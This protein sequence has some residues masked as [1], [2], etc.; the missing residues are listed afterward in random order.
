MMV[1]MSG[2]WMPIVLSAVVVFVASWAIHMFIGWHKGEYPAVPNQDAVGDALRPFNIAPG[3]Y[4]L[5]RPASTKDM[6]SPEY[7]AKLKRGP[8]MILTV[9]A[10]E[11]TKMGPMLGFWFLYCLAV[12]VCAAFLGG[13]T[14]HLGS[15]YLHVFKI[16]GTT[17]FIGYTAALW[18][19]WIWWGRTFRSTFMATVDGVIYAALTAGVFGWLWPR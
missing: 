4:L 1:G 18:Q 17:A 11:M 12:S 19:S 7:Q 5:P 9:R 10:N 14:M 13:R 2:L 3:E 16:I 6:G 15:T 8:V